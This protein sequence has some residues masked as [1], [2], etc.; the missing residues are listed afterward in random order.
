MKKFLKFLLIAFAY[1]LLFMVTNAILPFSQAF[2]EASADADPLS[3]VFLFICSIFNCFTICFIAANS[4]WRGMKR[5]VGIIFVVFMIAAFMTQIETLFFGGA[6]PVLTKF[7]VILIMLAMLPS[8]VIATLL[9]IQFFGSRKPVGKGGP[10]PIQPLMGRLAAL[11]LIYVAVYFLFGYFVAWQFEEVRVF[12]SGSRSNT[13]FI[14]QLMNNANDNPIIYPFQFI[15]G[16][17]FASFSLPLFFMLRHNKK[18]FVIS[19]CLVYLSTAV[20]LI[21][22][23]TLFPDAV[24]WAH[25]YEMASSMLLFGIITGLVLYVPEKR[26]Q[27]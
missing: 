8:I 7:D 16:I 13:G 18:K 14:G 10:V 4:N 17:M 21:L 26:R 9:G 15:R 22:P 2:T 19:C 20:V 27:K 23:N 6:F 25:F 11:G 5:A 3:A 1:T 24:R 12:Y